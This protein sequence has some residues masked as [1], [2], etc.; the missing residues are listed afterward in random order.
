MDLIRKIIAEIEQ[1]RRILVASHA[2]PEGDALG[3]SLAIAHHFAKGKKIQVINLDQLPYFLEFL[4]GADKIVH[5]LE[6][7]NKDFDLAVVVD[8]SDLDRVSA[9]FPALVQG[10]RIVNIDHH[11]TNRQFGRLNLVDAKASSTGEIIFQLLKQ[12]KIPLSRKTATCLY[13]ALMM[14]TGSFRYAN[15]SSRTLETAARL[16]ELGAKP[17][18]ISRSV[19]ESHPQAWLL[20]LGQVLPTFNISRDGRRAELTLTDEMYQA[21]G[22]G[23]EM[24][25]GLINYL[26]TVKGVEVAILYRQIPNHK[27][28]VSFRSRG[29]I[30]VAKLSEQFGGGGH[31][32]AAGAT[33]EGELDEIKQRVREKVDQ[34]LEKL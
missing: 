34:L 25:E 4:P 21:A 13:T 18:E 9:Q 20:L 17:G 22:A 27:F 26:M 14:D 6:Q 19:Y 23:K 3:S 11:E 30:N 31:D 5:T 33:L 32:M 29:K 8:C 2:N 24:S 10:R 7:V 12:T 16:V 15:T 1:A 28:K